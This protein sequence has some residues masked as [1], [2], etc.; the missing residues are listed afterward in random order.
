MN[1]TLNELVRAMDDAAYLALS[2]A[3][4]HEF[5]KEQGVPEEYHSNVQEIYMIW[6]GKGN[7]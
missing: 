5:L 1:K 7:G 4:R 2:Q 6:V 3:K